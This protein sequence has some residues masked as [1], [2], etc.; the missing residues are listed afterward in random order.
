M[1]RS[2]AIM[3]ILLVILIA[4]SVYAINR[5]KIEKFDDMTGDQSQV[6]LLNPDGP[7]PDPIDPAQLESDIKA[8][9]PSGWTQPD[10]THS[11]SRPCN[12]YYT[13]NI[14]ACDAGFYD[15]P[16]DSLNRLLQLSQ[17]YRNTPGLSPFVRHIFAYLNTNIP[18]VI[19]EKSDPNS[20][21]NLNGAGECKFDLL[22]QKGWIEPTQTPQGGAKNYKDPGYV[23]LGP[24]DTWAHCYK[25]ASDNDSGLAADTTAYNMASQ[26]SQ[27]SD[28]DD[29]PNCMLKAASVASQSPFGDNKMY[30]RISFKTLYLNNALT[31]NASATLDQYGNQLQQDP[32]AAPD[33]SG[34][35]CNSVLSPPAPNA[36]SSF[37]GFKLDA[38]AR[39]SDYN[40]F[41]YDQSSSS[42]YPYSDLVGAFRS[43]ITTRLNGNY[44]WI[45]P[46]TLAATIYSLKIN[47]FCKS[48]IAN[49]KI[50][51]KAAKV[52]DTNFSLK[53]NLRFPT[54]NIMRMTFS[55][56]DDT[57]KGNLD[58][59]IAK[60]DALKT[61]NDTL[62]TQLNAAIDPSTF[63]AG[64]YKYKYYV[65]RQPIMDS[66]DQVNNVFLNQVTPNTSVQNPSVV[67]QP[68]SFNEGSQMAVKY[69]GYIK[70]PE[71]GAYMFM[72]NSDDAGD[73]NL[74]INGVST[75]VATYYGYHWIF[76]DGTNSSLI[77]LKAGTY[78][79]FQ[80]RYIQW[81]GDAGIQL[82]W[83]RPSMNGRKNCPAPVK[84]APWLP[85]APG[86]QTQYCWQEI[87]ASAYFYNPN[88]PESLEIA[89]SANNAKLNLLNTTINTIND[90]ISTYLRTTMAAIKSLIL[91]FENYDNNGNPTGQVQ[92]EPFWYSND[93]W[94]YVNV[95]TWGQSMTAL[96]DSGLTLPNYDIP[97]MIQNEVVDISNTMKT[98]VSPAISFSGDVIYSFMSWI[99]IDQYCNQWRNLF[100]HGSG[101]DWSSD[102]RTD[103]TPGM[104]IYPNQTNIHFRHRT[105]VS[106][107]DGCDLLNAPSQN[108]NLVSF[109]PSRKKWFHIAAVVN[110]NK[111]QLYY[112]GKPADSKVLPS[113]QVFNW[114]NSNKQFFI[115][116]RTAWPA[117]NGS[118]QVQKAIWHNKAL[119]NGDISEAYNNDIATL[120]F[121]KNL[122][123]LFNQATTTGIYNMNFNGNIINVFVSVESSGKWLCILRY[124]HRGGTN[125]NLNVKRG[126]VTD[127]D[128]PVP[129]DPNNAFNLSGQDE[130]NDN[131]NWGHLSRSY[132]NQFKGQF[133]AVRFFGLTSS[134]GG[135]IN[136]Y[137]KDQGI[138][139][140][141][142]GARNNLVGYFPQTYRMSG[143]TTLSSP[144][145][146]N[147]RIPRYDNMQAQYRAVDDTAMTQEPIFIANTSHWSIGSFGYRWEVDD[148]ANN[149]NNNTLHMLFIGNL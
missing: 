47:R 43:M 87:P 90:A 19:Q 67:A 118:V 15:L 37:L 52:I 3:I 45:V 2:Y 25:L 20:E 122:N 75:P 58:Q 141:F 31:Q 38:N 99:K 54:Q 7:T 64:C 14:T 66:A 89:Q 70:I 148:Y 35:I 92:I 36:P 76:Y 48:K 18:P 95:G 85:G 126:G 78:I 57:L 12:V 116:Y 51:T 100:F 133:N 27:C 142:T 135:A 93:N 65:P 1:Q 29:N 79:Q 81:Y 114:H 5:C 134:G 143:F 136:F 120:I 96:K 50:V 107:N 60:R 23:S 117:M 110:V 24:P 44:L 102:Q 129:P 108:G 13:K 39:I 128:F 149:A 125:P 145:Q 106:N 113:G 124:S 101:D 94:L 63:K 55:D 40:V 147:S 49:G 71:D 56:S 105:N 42:I 131:T 112:N 8:M 98:I 59:L 62:T 137:T 82:F 61:V 77:N 144:V 132:L 146:H 123:D 140:L 130:S 28:K 121:P 34:L 10:T 4:A 73:F 41:S 11:T 139:D 30:S 103:R 91:T 22:A 119:A 72:I 46:D 115:N 83:Q 33:L 86:R 84:L 16:L 17:Q 68:H 97:I 26:F 88:G 32:T 80:A 127:S 53:I 104:W 69:T 9:L 6:G 111:I 109:Q 21:L 74:T 138:L